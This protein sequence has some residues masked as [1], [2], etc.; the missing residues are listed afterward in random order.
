MRRRMT[1]VYW[2]ALVLTLLGIAPHTF[3][4]DDDGAAAAAPAAEEAVPQQ[5][6]TST[7]TTQNVVNWGLPQAGFNPDAHLGSSSQSKTD[8]NQGDSFDLGRGSGAAQT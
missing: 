6:S 4:Q 5:Q 2:S 3:A 7:T 1:R 8:I